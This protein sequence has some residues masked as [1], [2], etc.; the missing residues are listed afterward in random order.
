MGNNTIEPVAV[1]LDATDQI[2]Y[3]DVAA[4]ILRQPEKYQY[5]FI[6]SRYIAEQ[7]D[8]GEMSRDIIRFMLGSWITSTPLEVETAL[9]EDCFGD[10]EQFTSGTWVTI[11]DCQIQWQGIDEM[12]IWYGI[13]PLD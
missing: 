11:G 5:V 4:E 1:L 7:D 3:N 13:R 12:T 9:W 2:I 6:F 10:Y 8:G